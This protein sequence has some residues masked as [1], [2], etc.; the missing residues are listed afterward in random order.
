MKTT[1]NPDV[2][3]IFLATLY[4][5]VAKMAYLFVY[6]IKCVLPENR[7]N[8]LG[9][10]LLHSDLQTQTKFPIYF[11]DPDKTIHFADPDKIPYTFC[12]PRQNSLYILQT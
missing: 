3:K 10:N 1:E 8:P 2:T 7:Q 9:H 6:L 4:I 11:A 12:R 5:F